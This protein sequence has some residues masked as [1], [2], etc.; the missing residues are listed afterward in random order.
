MSKEISKSSVYGISVRANIPDDL[1]FN[2]SKIHA[3]AIESAEADP[4]DDEPALDDS[5]ATRDTTAPRALA[6]NVQPKQ[7]VRPV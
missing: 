7:P 4:R 3:T 2:V 6:G 5:E 1:A